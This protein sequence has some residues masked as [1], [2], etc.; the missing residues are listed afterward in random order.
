MNIQHEMNMVSF[1]AEL[2]KIDFPLTAQFATDNF[3]PDQHLSGKEFS[4]AL[5]F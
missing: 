1:S 2:L 4:P 3:Q 5:C